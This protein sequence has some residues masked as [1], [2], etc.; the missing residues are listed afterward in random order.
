MISLSPSIWF[1][2]PPSWQ[3]SKFS[4]LAFWSQF[5]G[6]CWDW[7]AAFFGLAF[8]RLTSLL[9]CHWLLLLPD[10]PTTASILIGCQ[11]PFVRAKGGS[12]G[13]DKGR[14]GRRTA[15]AQ[16]YLLEWGLVG[17]G[18]G[19]GGTGRDSRH[20]ARSVGAE[21]GAAGTSWSKCRALRRLP[22][23]SYSQSLQR[24][25]RAVVGSGGPGPGRLEL[26]PRYSRGTGG[27][28]GLDAARG[29]RRPGRAAWAFG[30]RLRP[31]SLKNLCA[32]S[33]SHYWAQLFFGGG[34]ARVPEADLP[35][36][37][38]AS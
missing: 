22:D 20:G 12:S 32:T 35:P 10:P 18:A 36:P 3:L 31:D 27:R 26:R 25:V 2:Q 23:P 11:C 29:T 33:S 15:N 13:F 28:G 16:A 34:A 4:I 5:C 38:P 9:Y 24:Q 17:D 14:L 8:S 19:R 21:G 30:G 7:R 37:S 1:Y 6:S